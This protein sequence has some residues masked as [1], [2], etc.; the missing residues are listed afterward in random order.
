MT[1]FAIIYLLPDAA[2][3]EHQLLRSKIEQRFRLTGDS[4]PKTPSHITLKYPFSAE[5][6]EEVETVLQRFSQSQSK[7]RW[8]LNGFNHFINEEDLVIFIDVKPSKETREAHAR[9]LASLRQLDWMQWGPFD[10][11]ALHYHV[12]L[13]HLGLTRD[14][15]ARVWSFVSQQSAPKS[16]LF[17][18][19]MVLLEIDGDEHS[20][21]REFRLLDE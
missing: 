6:I 9:M 4:N 17:F 7:T 1:Q 15:F 10:H 2:S 13:A 19:N 8:S 3:D 12:T 5:N 18:D 11:P 14:N 20:V 21:Y 16:E